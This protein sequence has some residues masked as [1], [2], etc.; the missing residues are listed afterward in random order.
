MLQAEEHIVGT[1]LAIHR[2]RLEHGDE[3]H[4]ET[5]GPEGWARQDLWEGL[6]PEIHHTY[7]L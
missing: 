7:L 5:L 1:K 4:G 6:E 3:T 2:C